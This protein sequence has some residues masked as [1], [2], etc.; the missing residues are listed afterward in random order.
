[1]HARADV[2]ATKLGIICLLSFF[3]FPSTYLSPRRDLPICLSGVECVH[4]NIVRALA[5]IVATKLGIILLS[6]FFLSSSFLPV[7]FLPERGLPITPKIFIP[8]WTVGGLRALWVS[9]HPLWRKRYLI[10]IYFAIF[11]YVNYV[12]TNNFKHTFTFE[13]Q[14]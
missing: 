7:T 4:T 12:M 1:M 3:F 8:G 6:F 5:D 9:E 10:Y 11:Q 2:V 13:Y 14:F